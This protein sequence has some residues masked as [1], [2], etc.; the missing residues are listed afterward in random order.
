MN[1][2][3]RV[4]SLDRTPQRYKTFCDYNANLSFTKFSACDGKSLSLDGSVQ[5]GIFAAE[6]N[7]TAGARGVAISH[8]QLWQDAVVK[9]E[10]RHIAE[11]DAIIRYDFYNIFQKVTQN[12][13]SWDIILWSYNDDWPVGLVS[14][15]DRVTALKEKELSATFIDQ[16]HKKFQKE[17]YKPS[18]LRLAS[19]AGLGLYS[20]S[21]KGAHY[22]LQKCLPIV[23]CPASYAPD[24]NMAWANTG[25][26]VEMSRH[27]QS[28]NA[29]VAYP[30][31]AFMLNDHINS[32]IRG[33]QAQYG[34][35]SVKL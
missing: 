24:T 9:N 6:L 13:Q 20:V 15:F 35:S 14:T 16:N 4:I 8:I 25:L 3:I 18:L 7:Y 17:T 27:Y 2:S 26:D 12:D 30:P 31:M 21:P 32:T 34:V 23:G 33:N 22:L 19:A 28:L 1:N 29:Y 5:Q 11:D 10:V